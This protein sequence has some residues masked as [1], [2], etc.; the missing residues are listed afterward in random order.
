[1]LAEVISPQLNYS[2]VQ[3]DR[4]ARTSSLKQQDVISLI[5]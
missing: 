1:M 3:V 5:D 2:V 4:I